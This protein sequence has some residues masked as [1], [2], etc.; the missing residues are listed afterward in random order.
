MCIHASV[1]AKLSTNLSTMQ[2]SGRLSA[3]PLHQCLVQFLNWAKFSTRA[4]KTEQGVSSREETGLPPAERKGKEAG[5]SFHEVLGEAVGVRQNS[6][7]LTG[8]KACGWQGSWPLYSCLFPPEPGPGTL[9]WGA[10]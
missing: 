8:Q 6:P 9:D 3:S 4:S 5:M 1:Q 10:G 7:G 2:C